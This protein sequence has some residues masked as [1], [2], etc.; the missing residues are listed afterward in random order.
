MA[1]RCFSVTPKGISCPRELKNPYWG[2]ELLG[3][4]HLR[5]L[6]PSIHPAGTPYHWL[7]GHEPDQIPLADIPEPL[8]LAF[9]GD[10]PQPKSRPIAQNGHRVRV[11]FG[12][13]NN[14]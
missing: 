4:K 14:F 7:K 9:V 2:A 3:D 1:V 10:R 5:M 11:I 13:E 6:P 8:L 12:A